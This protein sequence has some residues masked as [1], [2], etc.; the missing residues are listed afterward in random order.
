MAFTYEVN[1]D[2][3]VTILN[4]G[5][6]FSVQKDDPDVEG[7]AAFAT[8]ARAEEWA[9]AAIAVYQEEILA[10]QAAAEE[11]VLAAEIE[12]E[13]DVALVGSSGQEETSAED[14]SSEE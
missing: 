10:E 5:Y 9:S 13:R 3:S 12:A 14:P 1:E 8:A 2:K 11:A 7:Y 6:V 4:D